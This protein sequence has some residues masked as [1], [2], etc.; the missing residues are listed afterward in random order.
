MKQLTDEQ[1]LALGALEAL[2]ELFENLFNT[3]D[4]TT[5]ISIVKSRHAEESEVIHNLRVVHGIAISKLARYIA[6]DTGLEIMLQAALT[7]EHMVVDE[8]KKDV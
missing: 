2:R 3:N 7:K 1:D 8:M 5:F 4:K 6:E